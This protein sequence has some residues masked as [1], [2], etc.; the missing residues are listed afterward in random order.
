MLKNYAKIW[1]RLCWIEKLIRIF[2]TISKI[3]NIP[4]HLFE[5]NFAAL[6]NELLLSWKSTLVEEKVRISCT[7]S[8]LWTIYESR[9]TPVLVRLWQHTYLVKPNT[10]MMT[11]CLLLTNGIQADTIEFAFERTIAMHHTQAELLLTRDSRK[12]SLNLKS[13]FLAIRHPASTTQS[14]LQFSPCP[15]PRG[16]ATFVTVKYSL[17]EQTTLVQ[18]PCQD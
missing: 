4:Q 17:H 18:N 8:E 14:P 7:K 9:I 1:S 15:V 13:H 5:R 11:L 16:D 6:L 2:S 10:S 12:V 3:Q